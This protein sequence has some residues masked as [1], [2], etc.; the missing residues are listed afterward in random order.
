MDFYYSMIKMFEKGEFSKILIFD[1][2]FLKKKINK[3]KNF[4]EKIFRF[5]L[6]SKIKILFFFLER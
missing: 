5:L 6:Y 2:F 3:I 1:F 4:K